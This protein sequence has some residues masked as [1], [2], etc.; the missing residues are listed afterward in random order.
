MLKKKRA[1]LRENLR[2][3]GF[4]DHFYREVFDRSCDAVYIA[5]PS[6][7]KIID[8]N[9]AGEKL[10]GRTRKEIIGMHQTR[11]HPP[12][13]VK[14]YTSM[15]RKHIKEHGSEFSAEVITKFGK[16]VPVSIS[17]SIVVLNGKKYILGNF[18]DLHDLKEMEDRLEHEKELFKRIVRQ[19]P[20]LVVGFDKDFRVVIFNIF[21]QKVTGYTEK[22]VLGKRWPDIFITKKLRPTINKAWRSIIK[23]QMIN[24][25]LVN[26][27]LT[28]DGREIL[29]SWN[30]TFLKEN[31]SPQMVLS[32]GEDITEKKQ[33]ELELRKY[34][35]I[36]DQSNQQLA[37]ADLSGNIVEANLSWANNHGYKRSEIL[38]K[39]LAIFHTREELPN[40]KRFNQELL[41]KGKHK[42]EILHKR[43]DGSVY[44]TIMDNFVLETEREKYLVGMATDITERKKVEESLRYSEEKYNALVN[45]T[46]TGYVIIDSTG[47]VIDANPEYIRLAGYKTLGEI[48]GR[49]VTEWTAKHDHRRNAEEVKKCFR[50]GSVRG[51]EIEYVDKSGRFTPIEINAN[52]VK[53]GGTSVVV[54]L[55]R[56]ITERKKAEE[57]IKKAKENVEKQVEERTKELKEAKDKFQILY[58][59]S[60]DAIMTLSP[61]NWKFTSGNPAT[62][63]MF[64]ISN[65]KKFTSLGPG[66]LS[67]KY[68]PDGELSGVKAKKMIN[69]AMKEGSNFFEWTHKTI[70]GKEF[71]ATVLL[72]VMY[73]KEKKYLQATVRDVTKQKENEAEVAKQR[74]FFN[75]IVENIPNMIFVKDAEKLRFELFN[76]AGED[77]LGRKREVF[78][79][80]ND[81]DFF[82]KK[83]AD[84]FTNKDREVL[85]DKKLLDIPEEPLATAKGERILHTK[86][87]P[88]LDQE[89]KPTHLLGI[90]EDITDRKL[91]ERELLK[92]R[93]EL[94]KKVEELEKFTKI[95]VGRELKMIELKKK[96]DQL[97]K[98]PE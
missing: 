9:R 69:R 73:E 29:V 70:D 53:F 28:K 66:Q 52:V 75:S 88:I 98:Q 77:L 46:D 71:P 65:E 15:F 90:S 59:S 1:G 32:V 63:E 30:N 62:L 67:P 57:E 72:S 24:H 54:T 14:L 10:I 84:F 7:G 12:G 47:R 56:D 34:K 2:S 83:Q 36:F 26:P 87:I 96:I 37:I 31:G 78:I 39:S 92:S 22:E 11:L 6:T 85:R 95:A 19:A 97:K 8:T 27:I 40:V 86:K 23:T 49:I 4:E 44:P 20:N 55:C 45:S 5:D 25:H 13:K 94:T 17:A 41:K 50:K 58:A 21:A 64:R 68:Q 35:F 3:C 79:G 82:P 74:H 76:K 91:T 60:R 81:Y 18:R 38:G 80:K 48:K 43:K 42:G 16:L 93:E 33:A 61:P 51:L 89:G